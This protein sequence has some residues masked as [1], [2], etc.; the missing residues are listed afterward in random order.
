M[1]QIRRLNKL[2]RN[3]EYGNSKCYF[4]GRTTNLTKHHISSQSNKTIK[5]CRGC[6]NK[7]HELSLIWVG[8]LLLKYSS[9]DLVKFLKGDK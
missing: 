5:L 9:G 4:C 6:H 1:F 3:T 8:S 7:F 2:E